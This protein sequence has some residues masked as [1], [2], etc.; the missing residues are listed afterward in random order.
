MAKTVSA[1]KNKKVYSIIAPETFGSQELGTTLANEPQKLK[2]RT[3]R[4]SLKDLT[5]DRSK[6]YIILTFKLE[7]VSNETVNTKFKKFNLSKGYLRSKVRKGISKIDYTK[8]IR[9]EDTEA[10]IK[11]IVLTPQS[12]TN[13]QKKEITTFMSKFL[14]D[15]KDK[16]SDQFVQEVLFGKIGTN[17]YH[18]LKSICP[19]KRIEVENIE[20]L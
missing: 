5:G 20:L 15:Y 1:W 4:V 19:I 13:I 11:I 6:Q 16:K 14:D 3:I 12:V 18:R 2:G 9:L 8:R 10:Q 17:I 7:N